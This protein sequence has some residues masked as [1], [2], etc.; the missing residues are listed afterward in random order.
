MRAK[1]DR[2]LGQADPG[3]NLGHLHK[4]ELRS[5]A[6]YHPRQRR[7]ADQRDRRETAPGDYDDG[8]RRMTGKYYT[9][10]EVIKHVA[11]ATSR[12]SWIYPLEN[13]PY[14]TQKAHNETDDIN[15]TNA[16]TDENTPGFV[17]KYG[18]TAE[19]LE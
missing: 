1:A 7:D 5:L 14:D 15:V 12:L 10:K 6:E 8:W 19:S 16:K 17:A 18:T 4:Q 9:P 13:P 3:D 11:G 2:L